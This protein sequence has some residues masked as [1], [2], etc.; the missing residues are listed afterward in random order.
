M[1][2]P[3]LWWKAVYANISS[4]SEDDKQS[5][6]YVSGLVDQSL[7]EVRITA[8]YNDG[9]HGELPVK[10]IGKGAFSGN[11]TI[12]KVFATETLTELRGTAF[13]NCTNL[14]TVVIP[15]VKCLADITGVGN[16]WTRENFNYCSSLTKIV[17][18]EGFKAYGI[19][20]RGNS[21]GKIAIYICGSTRISSTQL[22]IDSIYGHNAL[23]SEAIYAY[24]ATG[25]L[26]DYKYWHYNVN[27]EPVHN[28]H[29]DV[30]PTDNVDGI[31]DKCGDA[32][33]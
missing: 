28:K 19:N 8:T 6:Y 11:N 30:K 7:T 31:C 3:A 27:G 4:F 2:S 14:K 1:T 5:C 15:G 13:S 24:D 21:G 23:I 32:V 20:F 10:Y 18:G 16:Y 12:T 26:D 22:W 9:V 17:V 25:L 33:A 29:V